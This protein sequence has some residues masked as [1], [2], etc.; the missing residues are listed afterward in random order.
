MP[1]QNM[2]MC[3]SLMTNRTL[4][5]PFS[6]VNFHVNCKI[7]S[8]IEAFEA[9]FARKPPFP[10]MGLNVAFDVL[11]KC[12]FIWAKGASMNAG[13]EIESDIWKKDFG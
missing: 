7:S 6:R 3:E 12:S 11:A 5:R 10:C 4:K 2:L 1:R 8:G 9:N 13:I